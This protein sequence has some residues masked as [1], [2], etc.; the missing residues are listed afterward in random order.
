MEEF[1]I[2]P[3]TPRNGRTGRGEARRR[4]PP[5]KLPSNSTEVCM[6]TGNFLL[7]VAA[8]LAV[9]LMRRGPGSLKAEAYDSDASALS[10]QVSSAEEGAT[11]G[12]LVRAK[13]EV[14]FMRI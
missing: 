13:R 12:V 6:R 9:G 8:C 7:I 14:V 11:E 2:P 1:R 10:G 5:E 3:M 4:G